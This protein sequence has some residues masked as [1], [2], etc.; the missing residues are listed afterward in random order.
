MLETVQDELVIR[1]LIENW[2]VWRDSGN[3]DRLR[4]VWHDDGKMQATWFFGTADEFVA[5][6]RGAWDRGLEVLHTLNGTSI[7]L[8]GERGVAQ[9]KMEIHQRANV[10]GIICDCVCMGRFY[11]LFEKR[12]GKWGLVLRQPIYEKDRLDPVDTSQKL[13]LDREKLA[14]LPAGYRHLA[15]LQLK[16]GM[17]VK[18]DLPGIKGPEVEALYLQGKDWLAGAKEKE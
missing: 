8:C 17:N 12:E 16:I 6:S 1:K 9:T 11:D 7:D 15:Y 18:L 2:V 14:K 10:D 3:W 13:D 5:A 4:S